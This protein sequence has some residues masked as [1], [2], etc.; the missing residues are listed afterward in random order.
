MDFDLAEQNYVRLEKLRRNGQITAEDYR[1]QLDALR[2]VDAQGRTW[3]VQEQTGQ[4]FVWDGAQWQPSAPAGRAGVIAVGAPPQAAAP[5]QTYYPQQQGY[6]PQ[7]APQ[8][9]YP[10]QPV[11]VAP[12]YPAAGAVQAAPVG[13]AAQPVVPQQLALA[14]KRPGCASVTLR[15]LL[16]ALVWGAAAWAVDALPRITPWWAY[17]A[18]GLA[19]LVTLIL[20]VRRITR[21]GRAMRRLAQGGAA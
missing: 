3:M 4:W 19:A 21:F 12:A 9:A 1:A 7:P 2:V 13:Y 14:R 11:Y 5:M 20:L 8:P 17:V 6:A 15:M 10:Q 16:W 18:V